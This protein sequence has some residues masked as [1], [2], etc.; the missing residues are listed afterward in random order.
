MADNVD[1][2]HEKR[3]LL[4]APTA[5]D[6]EITS[7]ILG[8]A[9]LAC[10]ACKNLRVAGV[11]LLNGAATVLLTEEALGSKDAEAFLGVLRGQPAWSDIPVIALMSNGGG[12]QSSAATRVLASLTN[13]TLLERP[14]PIRS[15]V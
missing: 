14:A 15:I 8:R 1:Q 13:L 11:E 2:Q 6:A 12:G 10:Q 5:R 7:G 3:V 4:V 9:G